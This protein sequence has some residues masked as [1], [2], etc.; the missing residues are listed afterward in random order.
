MKD[1]IREEIGLPKLIFGLL[2]ATDISLLA[3]LMENASW[4]DQF[5]WFLVLDSREVISLAV[6]IYLS[7]ILL[8]CLRE[9][10]NKINVIGEIDEH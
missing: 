1:M 3:W 7:L 6:V 10:R 2:F 8:D 4:A 5:P 9:V